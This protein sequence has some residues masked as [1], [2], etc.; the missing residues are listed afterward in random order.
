M[1]ARQDILALLYESLAELNEFLPAESRFEL[2]EST[3]LIADTGG[4]D[5]LG[6]VNF[7]STVEEKLERRYGRYISLTATG[8]SVSIANP[9]TDVG[10]LAD[11]ILER[12]AAS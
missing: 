1:P 5:S 7:V 9:W 6:T 10:G 8:A 12:A 3:A 11:F 4:L 2:A